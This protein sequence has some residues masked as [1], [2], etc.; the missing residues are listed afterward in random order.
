MKKK[1]LAHIIVSFL[2]SIPVI[3]LSEDITIVKCSGPDDCDLS[4]LVS[5][6]SGFQKFLFGIAA[7]LAAVA[8]AIIG[9]RGLMHPDS[10]DVKK[11]VM[12]TVKNI[13]IGLGIFLLAFSVVK[14]II[15]ELVSPSINALRF[16]Q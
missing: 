15:K 8:F 2:V 1:I 5:L 3:V 11:E 9:V 10:V 13:S 4:D 12:N 16:L 7:S 6:G 14:I